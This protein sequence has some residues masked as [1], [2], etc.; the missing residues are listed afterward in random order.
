MIKD[1]L[2]NQDIRN[3]AKALYEL[4]YAVEVDFWVLKQENYSYEQY[5]YILFESNTDFQIANLIHFGTIDQ[6][7]LSS[8][9]L[10]NLLNLYDDLVAYEYL[11]DEL[12]LTA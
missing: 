11:D 6:D 9:A 10:S 12:K 2:T 4:Q 7:T 1:T 8:T 3:V 5:E